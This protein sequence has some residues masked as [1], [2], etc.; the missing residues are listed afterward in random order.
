MKI[1]IWS[2]VMCPF[3]YI[4]KRHLE[5][6]IEKMNISDSTEIIWKSYQLDPTIPVQT[7]RTSV[8]EY[9]ADSKGISLEQSKL[10]HERVLDMAKN[11]GLTYNFD[12][13]IV[14]NS[15]DAHRLIQLAKTKSLGDQMEEE[16]FKAY[17]TDGKD[18]ASED[19]LFEIG[20]I[21]GLQENELT[22]LLNSDLFSE[23]LQK[24]LNEAQQIG[25]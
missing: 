22:E 11:A 25:I 16:L 4:G 12:R 10:M 3:C 7:K 6:A 9:L 21:I 13:A 8:F 20:K 2:D 1:E 18:I 5:K 19:D 24:D 17:F 15:F 23:D 14:G